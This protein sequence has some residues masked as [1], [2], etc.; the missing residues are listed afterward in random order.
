MYE[1]KT[2]RKKDLKLSFDV[3]SFWHM[4]KSRRADL[5]LAF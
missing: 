1:A 3:E 4:P 2:K 5:L